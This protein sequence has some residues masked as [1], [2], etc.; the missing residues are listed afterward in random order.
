MLIEFVDVDEHN[1]R[2]ATRHRVSTV[3]IVQVFAN[4]PVVRRNRRGRAADYLATGRTDGGSGVSV[5]FDH[6]PETGTFR[7]LAA[8]RTQ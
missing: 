1:E 6:D 5:A 4:N 2:H 7:P 8:W 3:E